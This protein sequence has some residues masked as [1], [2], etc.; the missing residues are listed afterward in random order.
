[1]PRTTGIFLFKRSE[2]H[3]SAKGWG[4]ELN[5]KA[6]DGA[7]PRDD[8][9]VTR[10]EPKVRP[11][12]GRGPHAAGRLFCTHTLGTSANPLHSRARTHTQHKC[13]LVRGP[14]AAAACPH[15]SPNASHRSA[16]RAPSLRTPE[17]PGDSSKALG[18]SVTEGRT[19]ART[20]TLGL[21]LCPPCTRAACSELPTLMGHSVRNV[22]DPGAPLHTLCVLGGVEQSHLCPWWG[23]Q[24]YDPVTHP[25]VHG[26]P[27]GG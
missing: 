8:S 19:A 22:L 21:V 1:M 27:G 7:M 2:L 10:W 11:A 26:R 16:E 15:V 6:P 9:P 24:A 5:P 14:R 17:R 13:K 12:W 3:Q 25:T 23:A 20:H 18:H 4:R